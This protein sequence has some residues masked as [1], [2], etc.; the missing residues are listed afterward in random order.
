MPSPLPPFDPKRQADR[1]IRAYQYQFLETAIAWLELAESETLFVEVSEDFDTVSEDGG[2]TLT[3]VT[4]ATN[5]RQLTLA[6][7]KS[8]DALEN[9]WTASEGGQNPSISLVLHTNMPPGH[10]KGSAL[11]EGVTGIEYWTKAQDG[12]A[13]GPLIAK[14]IE[15]QKPGPLLDW[16]KASPSEEAFR[17]R[18]LNRITWRV[19]QES[20]P[21]RKALLTALIK[22]RL[23]AIG[24]PA[25]HAGNATKLL[26][27]S[28]AD[29]AS[30]PDVHLRRLT[31]GGLNRFLN[32]TTR[33]DQPGHES[34][35]QLAS[36]TSPADALPLPRLCAARAPLTTKLLSKLGQ[37]GA[38]W[39]HGASGTGKSTLAQQIVLDGPGAW[40]IIDFRNQEDPSEI[41]LRLERAYTDVTLTDHAAGVILDDVRPEL[42]SNNA[43]RFAMF[44]DWLKSKG[45][46]ALVTSAQAPSPAFSAQLGM[47]P[48]S[49]IEA[50]YLE[51]T[52]LEE[53]VRLG[54]APDE[55]IETWSAFIHTGA[56]FGHPQLAAAKVA[57]LQGRSWPKEALA[58][59]F[60]GKT[61]EAVKLTQRDAR[62]R[63]MREASED[64]RK[65][66]K[67]LACIMLRFDRAM[68]IDAAAVDP[69]IPDPS[70]SLDFLIG[71]WIERAPGTDDYYRLSPLLTNL[72]EDLGADEIKDVQANLVINAVKNA[73]VSFESL[74]IVV[75]NAIR[76]EQG[77]FFV[78]S[79]KSLLSM[80]EEQS[81]AF[82]SK[83]S[84]ITI[85]QTDE[86]VFSSD[87]GASVIVRLI[88]LDIAAINRDDRLFQPIAE[89]ALREA[90]MIPVDEAKRGIR[91]MAISKILFAQGGRLDWARRL[92]WIEEYD[93]FSKTDPLF[94]DQAKSQ[95]VQDLKTEFGEVADVAGFL[96]TIGL[97]TIQSP[98]DLSSLFA[99]LDQ[100]EN[101]KRQRRLEQFKAF[102]QGYD[103]YVQSSWANAWLSGDL[104]VDAAITAYQQMEAQ[105]RTW[106]DID[107]AH[108]CLIAQSVL[109]DE[110]QQDRT[111]AQ[112]LIEEALEAHPGDAKLMR[113]KA[114]VLG[115]N[116]DY[117]GAREILAQ[118]KSGLTERSS[119]DQLYTLKEEAVAAA[120][121]GDLEEA[122]ELFLQAANIH[123]EYT[124]DSLNLNCHKIALRAEAALC[125]WRLDDQRVALHELAEILNDTQ[126]IKRSTSDTTIMLHARMRW[127]IGWIHSVTTAPQGTPPPKLVAGA[128]SALDTKVL[129]DQRK[130]RGPIEDVKVLLLVS[131]LQC[132]VIDVAPGIDWTEVT[133]G[134]PLVVTG[135][136]F[137][138]AVLSR[139]PEVI[140]TA[141]LNIG[142]A[143]RIASDKS[144]SFKPALP[145][146]DGQGITSEHLEFAPI[147]VALE[148]LVSVAVFRLR[149]DVASLGEFASELC[150]ALERR[151]GSETRRFPEIN[152][153]ANGKAS[154][155]LTSNAGRLIADLI[156]KRRETL[157]PRDLLKHHLDLIACA[158]ASGAG[159]RTARD[160]LAAIAEDWNYVVERQRF[161]LRDPGLT[162]PQLEHAIA[163]VRDKEPGAL[164]A[165][166]ELAAKNLRV[167]LVETWR[168]VIERIGGAKEK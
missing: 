27:Q 9:F 3:Q 107:L 151:I 154:N 81:A 26:L 11:P 64:G 121:L 67:R 130:D 131:A 71:P 60:M 66:L 14:L 105:A 19:S 24:L 35:W 44:F 86:P 109:F 149:Q 39:I 96:L 8:R 83:L 161:A 28:V 5:D 114:K 106:G 123:D 47:P 142:V 88:Q 55:L 34:R 42:I 74:D 53:M 138:L 97:Q 20:G 122:R 15:T 100:L 153:A 98:E 103:L 12:A 37:T 78:Q 164:Y 18:V 111:K 77:W 90:E 31:A 128:T 17:N 63:L 139:Q 117:E 133:T 68:A 168:P 62:Q 158:G 120:R 51:R 76:S 95:S 75:W 69:S 87:L 40:L 70:A 124:D 73:P 79:F 112:A 119:V 61:S 22:S 72:N 116:D 127:L 59:D 49:V 132:G 129:D 85:L 80:D 13:L 152:A 1:V 144:G 135:A 141:I 82:A 143:L 93:T 89:A 36:W 10:E 145:I 148:Q 118:L 140:V 41:L 30:D 104:N 134:F 125:S 32:E 115:H 58:E 126:A 16:L 113:Q 155:D 147:R 167:E 156:E 159:I 91:I 137:D 165:L 57:S 48:D 54:K 46:N 92:A 50:P 4:L 160:V 2:T 23:S 84:T 163:R 150:R 101:D 166:L 157:H 146:R 94:E 99:A 25:G 38:L 136:E 162:V 45:R 65:L 29:T 110:M 52:D 43:W 6:S 102:S 21:D 7:E 33:K 56:A 108:Q